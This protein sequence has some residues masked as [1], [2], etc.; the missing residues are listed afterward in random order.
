M[1]NS[2]EDL[3]AWQEAMKLVLAVYEASRH[4]PSDEVYGLR[5]QMRRAAVS[6]P[7]NIAEGQARLTPKDFRNFLGHARGSLAELHTQ[8]LLA[9]SL[10]Y[11]SP[12]LADPLLAVIARTGRLINGLQSSI[13]DR[14]PE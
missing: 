8:V 4:F 12:E 6:V 14:I 3:I 9:R 11:V 7:S 10:G 2:Y 1:S 13:K 5:A